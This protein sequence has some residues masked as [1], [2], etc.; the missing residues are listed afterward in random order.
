MSE[1][2][3]RQLIVRA[4]VIGGGTLIGIPFTL[5]GFAIYCFY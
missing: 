3:T 4:V 5:I 1:A 2:E